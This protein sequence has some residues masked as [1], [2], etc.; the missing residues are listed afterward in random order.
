MKTDK[1]LLIVPAALVGKANEA[2][3]TAAGRLAENTFVPRHSKGGKPTHAVACWRMTDDQL[4]KF[5]SEMSSDIAAKSVTT[6]KRSGRK[7][8]LSEGF[9]EV[10]KQKKPN[11]KASPEHASKNL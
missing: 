9:F 11:P 1:T 8:L 2:A 7:E 6:S 5:R 3:I 4:S 10:A